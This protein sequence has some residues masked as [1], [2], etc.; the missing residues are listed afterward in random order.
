MYAALGHLNVVI[1]G[2][3]SLILTGIW[4]H[5]GSK[6]TRLAVTGAMGLIAL[7]VDQ[8]SAHYIFERSSSTRYIHHRV[9]PVMKTNIAPPEPLFLLQLLCHDPIQTLCMFSLLM[10]VRN[11]LLLH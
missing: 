5:S 11:T 4:K 10:S 9:R 6:S 7:P 1:P 3:H 2:R 8:K